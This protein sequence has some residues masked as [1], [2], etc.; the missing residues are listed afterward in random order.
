M[1]SPVQEAVKTLNDRVFEHRLQHPSRSLLSK[2][3]PQPGP[4]PSDTECVISDEFHA[5][6]VESESDPGEQLL[7]ISCFGV[8]D[9]D[10]QQ[11]STQ[12]LQILDL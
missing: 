7:H 3:T 5:M 8:T 11:A 6:F 9:S 2:V 4:L 10:K 1:Y 12:Q